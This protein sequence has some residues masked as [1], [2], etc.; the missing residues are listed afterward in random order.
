MSEEP[1][2]KRIYK[3]A[4]IAEGLDD[5]KVINALSVCGARVTDDN[6]PIDYEGNVGRW[7][8]YEVKVS[9]REIDQLQK[10]ILHGW[11]AHFWRGNTI[12]VVFNDK[13]F[14]I[15]RDDRS[16]WRGAV[17]HGRSQGIPE[18]ELDFPTQ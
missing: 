5:P 3:G 10:H 11:Y 4:V 16:T 13:L 12:L 8:I 6:M 17:A 1:E 15:K 14:R 7:H 2:E 9:K 18:D